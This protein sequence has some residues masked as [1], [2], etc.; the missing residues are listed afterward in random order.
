MVVAAIRCMFPPFAGPVNSTSS[1][2]ALVREPAITKVSVLMA[3][4]EFTIRFPPTPAPVLP[5]TLSRGPPRVTDSSAVMVSVPPVIPPVRST[6]P[7][8]STNVADRIVMF[9]QW[10]WSVHD[11]VS[12]DPFSVSK[13]LH[14]MVVSSADVLWVRIAPPSVTSTSYILRSSSQPWTSSF[15]E[16]ISHVLSVIVSHTASTVHSTAKAGFTK[17]LSRKMNESDIGFFGVEYKSITRSS[18]PN[19][20][21]KVELFT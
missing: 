14:R 12:G 21:H 10:S 17:I 11:A 20:K 4:L 1:L 3:F 19:A 2:A 6:K 7:W 15:S 8:S 16:K 9:P 5:C 18:V 13:L